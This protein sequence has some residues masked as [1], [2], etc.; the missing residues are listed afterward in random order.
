M[1][2]IEVYNRKFKVNVTPISYLSSAMATRVKMLTLTLKICT[3][4][5]SLHMKAGR[6]HRCS[7]A[8]Q[9]WNGIANTAIVTSATGEGGS[10]P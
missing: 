8:A 10:H 6:S 7:S 5:Q 2:S 9:N 1:I 4:G 3:A